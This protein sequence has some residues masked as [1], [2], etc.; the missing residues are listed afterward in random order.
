MYRPAGSTTLLEPGFDQGT[1]LTIIR[2]SGD[3]AVTLTEMRE[4]PEF[5]GA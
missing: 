5:A 3:G 1:R 4:R 2:A